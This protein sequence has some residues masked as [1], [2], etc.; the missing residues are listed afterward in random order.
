[1]HSSRLSSSGTTTVPE[2]DNHTPR[3]VNVN[4]HKEQS[5]AMWI[6]NKHTLYSKQAIKT[7]KKNFLYLLKLLPIGV[8]TSLWVKNVCQ[9]KC[10]IKVY[11]GSVPLTAL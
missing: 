2:L 5:T 3:P 4:A 1:M 8:G 9:I 6:L 10:N 7:L 11:S